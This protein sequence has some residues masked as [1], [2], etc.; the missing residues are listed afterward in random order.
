[1]PASM[2]S[3]GAKG[4]HVAML[5]AALQQ[6]GLTIPA[7]EAADSAFGKGTEQALR[8]FQEAQG[9]TPSGEVDTKT[10]AALATLVGTTAAAGSAKNGNGGK[11]GSG[12]TGSK[13][14]RGG[15][16]GK[17]VVQGTL[18]FDNGLPAAA[19][20]VHAY[21]V[22][23]GGKDVKLGAAVAGSDG[24][25]L[26][27]YRT[28]SGTFNLQLRAVNSA[29]AEITISTTRYNATADEILN[30]VVPGSGFP[31]ASEYQR[32]SKDMAQA[33]GGIAQ[34]STA[35][36]SAT[37]QD[38]TLLTQSTN[39]D[40]RLVALAATAAQQ[41]SATGL[42]QEVL[43]ALFRIGL[44]STPALLAQV[45]LATVQKALSSADK[46]GIV[47]LT[48][49]Q[50]RAATT[51]FTAF[52]SKTQLTL[53]A[54]GTVSSYGALL[55]T[56]VP[57]ASQQA[58]FAQLYFSQPSSGAEL[59]QQAAALNIPPQTI[60][61]LKLQGKFLHLTQNNAVLSN[62]LQQDVGSLDNLAQLAENDYHDPA[63]WSGAL[64]GLATGS[65]TLDQLIPANYQ[66][67]TTADR[68]ASYAGDLA[69]KVRF[70]FPTQVA[71]RLIENKQ[72]TLPPQTAA[73]VT[74]FLRSAAAQGYELGKTPLNTFLNNSAAGANNPSLP[75]LPSLDQASTDSLKSLHRLYQ[76]TPSNE[77]LQA[78]LSQGFSSAY[79]IASHSQEAFNNK[80][81]KAFPSLQEAGMVY[82]KAQQVSSV[83][84]N[85][86]TMAKQLDSAPPVYAMSSSSS[87][88][89]NAKSAIVQ[90]F[91]TM[92]S[93]FGSVDFCQCE[94]CRSVL[95]PAA[96]FVDLLEYL[97]QSTANPAGYLPLDVLLGK[98]GIVPGRR[99]DLG[100]LPLTCE[101]TNTAL[102]YIDLVN[103]IFEY[104]ILNARLD[105]NVAY[106]TGT[107]STAD[108]T[109]EPQH[110]LA[111]VY[112]STLKQAVY[113]H[114]LPFD[115]WIETVRGFLDYFNAPLAQLLNT[116]RPVDQLELFGDA[117]NF[118]WYGA[119][120]LAESLRLSPSEY[121][122]LTVT[123]ALSHAPSVTNWFKLYG[124]SDENTAL[125]GQPDPINI[126]QFL[127]PPL[128][129]AQNLAQLLGLTYQEMADMVT[130][131]FLNPA[132]YPL[133]FQ[134]ER[135]GIASDDAFSYTGQAG[136]PTLTAQQTSDFEAQLSALTAQYKAVNP[137]SGF[138]AKTWLT[139]L[140]P[141]NY[142]SK[143][144]VLYDPDTGCDFGGTSLQY[145]DGSA[146]TQVDF[147]KI[148]LLV[149]LWKKT[150][151][152]LDESDRALQAFFPGAG[153]P[154]WGAANFAGSF[155][156][157]W[158]TAL[159]YIAH[160]D[161]LNTRLAPALGR[162]AL[163]P[164]WGNLGTQGTTQDT[165]PLYSQL[166]MTPGV[167]TGDWAFDDPSG[168]F[169][170]N[171][172]DLLASHQSTVQGVLSLNATEVAAILAD[173]GLDIASASFNLANL[174]LCYRYSLLAQCLQLSVADLISLKALSG[175]NP[176]AVLSN[177]PLQQQ[178]D[179]LLGNQTLQFVQQ[180]AAVQASGFSVA[181]L[182]YLLR[183][184]FDPQ[185][186]YQPDQNALMT[187]LQALASGLQQIQAQNTPAANLTSL[188]DAQIDQMLAQLFPAAL[189]KALFA[190]LTNSQSFTASQDGVAMAIDATPFAM[191]TEL[192]FDY[193]AV[194]QVQS[195]T[196]DGWL[197]DGKKAQLL[198]L[199][200]TPL[201]AGLLLQVQQ[202]AQAAVAQRIADLL[203]VWASLAE[204]EAVKTP[205]AAA[206]P[207]APL[208]AVDPALSLAYNQA[209][210]LQWLAYR[211]VLTASARSA[212]QAV[213]NGP[214]LNSLLDDIALQTSA[215]YAALIGS[216]LGMLTSGQIFSAS[217]AA[218]ASANQLSPGLFAAWPQL[219]LSYDPVSQTQTLSY[220]GLLDSVTSTAIAAVVPTSA[221]LPVLLAAV[222][223]QAQQMFQALA[224]ANLTATAAQVDG[225]CAPFQGL[226]VVA[227]QKQVKAG[228]VQVFL[229]LQGKK[230]SQQLILQTLASNLSAT[231]SLTE[232]LVTDAALL[233]DPS[234]PGKA[235]LGSFLA[236][237]Q[238]GVTATYYAAPDQSGPI[239][240]TGT[241]A[242]VDS[243][244][245]S[246]P[247]AGTGGTGSAHFEGYIQ[248]P[249]SGTYQFYALLGDLNAVLTFQLDAPDPG[250]L[251]ANPVLQHTAIKAGDVASQYVKL[252]GGVAYHFQVDL[253]QM[254]SNGA[255]FLV[256][257][258]SLPKGPLNR[259]LL[260]PQQAVTA[261][262]RARLL[263]AKVLQILATTGL[264]EREISYLV[265]N[266]NQFG[267]L[268]LAAM[269]TQA[270]DDT[271]ANAQA[272]FNWLRVLVDYANL[273]QSAAGSTDG[274]VNVFK[275]V[276]ITYTEA[277]ASAD[278][279]LNPDT[280]WASLASLTRRDPATVR[281][282]AD[283]F[284]L[285]EEAVVGP[286]RQVT[287]VGDFANNKGLR[288]LWQALQLQQIIGAP[289]AALTAAA[290]IVAAVLPAGSPTPDIIAT[291]LKN[292][293][294]AQYSAD[295]WQPISQSVFD[296][297][298]QKKR[299]ALVSY[300]VNQLD[301]ENQNQLFEYFLI[302][303]GM[304][305]VVQT[306]RL[307]L[308]LSSI[309]TFIQRCL[310]N[311]ENGNSANPQRNVSPT[312][313]DVDWWAWMK[314]YRVWQANREIFLF[315]ENWME[316]ELRL[317]KTDLFQAL[318]SSLLQDDVTIDLANSAFLT[319]LQG[320]DVVARL[321][322][323]AT[324][325]E[326]NLTTPDIST[327]HVLGR[328]YGS[329]HKYFYRTFS[330]GSWSMWQAVKPNIDGNHIVLAVWRGRLNIFWLTFIQQAQPPSS[331]SIGSGSGNA[332][333]TGMSLSSLAGNIFD[334]TAQA[335]LQVQL[336]W[337]ELYDGKWS[338]CLSSNTN[339]YNAQNPFSVPDGFSPDQDI[340]V[341]VS[342]EMDSSG[343]EAGVRIHLDLYD[344]QYGP[345]EGGYAFRVTSKNSDPDFD[346]AYWL[347]PSQQPYNTVGVGGTLYTGTDT[348]AV[349][350]E[351]MIASMEIDEVIAGILGSVSD[352][353]LLP[354]GNPVVPPFLDPTDPRYQAAGALVSPFFFRDQSGG[355]GNNE[356]TFY[357][358]PTLTEQTI[359]VWEG[360]A[361]APTQPAHNW[362]DPG[363]ID[364]IDIVAQMPIVGVL[365]V[366]PVDPADAMYV[367]NQVSDWVTNPRT[368]VAFGNALIGSGGALPAASSAAANVMAGVA[369]ASVAGDVEAQAMTSAV[370]RQLTMRG[371]TL[372]GGQGLSIAAM[373][374]SSELK[375]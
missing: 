94:E 16:G 11:G 228:L 353:S 65:Q 296:K 138:D 232:S 25:Y 335:Q 283:Y 123:D 107:A 104:Y 276:G 102:P 150:G 323:V 86:F 215:G 69:R 87:D 108:L 170:W 43:Y 356:L 258:E 204:Y 52:A 224:G 36:E 198:L 304:E 72:L 259:V 141:A 51:A 61:A 308:A 205:V 303:P 274:L 317:D 48:A 295:A 165:L 66:G 324:Y 26:I 273:R 95:S 7:T 242:T 80:Y 151:W 82:R 250:G 89:E 54:P 373:Q 91:P 275:N 322:I 121:Q 140:L 111:P 85:A 229:S 126:G 342:T 187:L 247:N 100:A 179:D 144:L 70:S 152:S 145:A 30:L 230:L 328:T 365:P 338:E 156:T 347:A 55:A 238:A 299:D 236:I 10:A 132:L 169:P 313:L 210:Q 202:Q 5:Q 185:G 134:F 161:D 357:V 196:Y 175:L 260:Y 171:S 203:G 75:A 352:Y 192:V 158:K 127:V 57:D 343:N 19:V 178:A 176:F 311:L 254:G 99:P 262:T 350:Y 287:A 332:S 333:A 74:A 218:V 164:L 113:P 181:D 96:Y 345:G 22:V 84:F 268:M 23:F 163:L 93:L 331:T 168:I 219:Q 246:N 184:Q 372:V 3:K 248:V 18:V 173:A 329:P 220:Q 301:L 233:T 14:S 197:T 137:A 189:P 174:S 1:M 186:E 71:A 366:N 49:A 182:Q 249:S 37:R 146:A 334:A 58:A 346:R 279:N 194:N 147:L 235:L 12:G 117:N 15:R 319:Y 344:S 77:S 139:G 340:Y 125:N 92:A 348:L 112:N 243:A 6:Q 358:Q 223:N 105:A 33:I 237:S 349:S 320:L 17:A 244:D 351:S 216:L 67:S 28:Q 60:D 292:A 21:S 282:M 375:A 83:T 226:T 133:I 148:S 239:L 363:I 231:A 190:L 63:T 318:E 288:R 207:A 264:D 4:A 27:S 32:L 119:Q 8:K 81:A 234:N 327:L 312:A 103:E 143:V 368:I 280:P 213:N 34:L 79:D 370:S 253:Q 265:A 221:P 177:A 201:F 42:G 195:V 46:A 211:G 160:L 41:S 180:V 35:Q 183:Q 291:N 281:A 135:F 39:W 172:G 270:S 129:V 355:I 59:W 227:M 155:S 307:R 294:M 136:F 257:G 64:S 240:A 191:E 225:F 44:P 316:P 271:L 149:R 277:V 116:L 13:G 50:T 9:L 261:F 361:L 153:L 110:T 118:P 193:D 2:L 286:L 68:L 209:S 88:R 212:L 114:N 20:S 38:L 306:S 45:P 90:Q 256:Q 374:Q 245:P 314:R 252:M 339:K 214:D 31:L 109:A 122:V 217:Q 154:S 369:V 78:A 290:N 305:P 167:L 337:T 269:P 62:K 97:R 255:S 289:V 131:G 40:A 371:I 124:Y 315:P 367:I 300:L 159:V 206:I 120:I 360:W 53:T 29:G 302:D 98:D 321:D 128:R 188:P 285:I 341:H 330:S 263:L 362:Y 241:A 336:H 47:N 162:V 142:S 222:R 364:H 157:A 73:N 359:S 251:F 267:N 278:T 106:D 266:A 115:L 354:C 298:R 199:N 293:V 310:L 208:Y 309:Q 272:L 24:S 297:L 284:G 130:T 200:G 166:F 76:V 326:Q 56:V 325:L 101:N